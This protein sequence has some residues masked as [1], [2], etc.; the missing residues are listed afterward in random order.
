MPVTVEYL[1]ETIHTV[2]LSQSQNFE[3]GFVSARGIVVTSPG[4]AQAGTGRLTAILFIRIP[5]IAP[6]QNYR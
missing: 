4:L 2:K 3:A 5:E 1:S 6:S